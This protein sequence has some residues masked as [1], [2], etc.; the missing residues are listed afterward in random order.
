[1]A[2]LWTVVPLKSM[3]RIRKLSAVLANRIAAGEVVERPASVVK[4]LA[5]NS[6]DAGARRVS[7][8]L[9]DGGTQLIVVVDDGVGM[10]RDDAVLAV[11]RFATSKIT[12]ADDLA[13]IAT[14][15]FRGEALPSIAAVSRMRILT[16]PP[17]A[18]EG[19]E[20]IIEGGELKSV[21]PAGC[22]PGTRVEVA[23]LFFNTPARRKFLAST[24]TERGHCHDWILRL[25]MARPD[26]AFRIS[27]N[28]TILFTSTG[29]GDLLPVL[30]AA[31]GSNAARQFVPV[32][33]Q[34]GNLVIDGYVSGPRL[35]RAT[36]QHQFFFVNRRFVRS[37]ILS[38]ALTQAYGSLL[39]A[40]RQP[41]CALHLVLPATEVDPNVHPTKIEVKFA[42]EGRV[43][44]AVEAAVRQ[45]LQEAGLR[46]RPPAPL[47]DRYAPPPHGLSTAARASR[48]RT[49]PIADKLDTRDDG[50]EVHTRPLQLDRSPTRSRPPAP[51]RPTPAPSPPAG[52]A[53]VLGQMGL[54]YIVVLA[55]DELLIIDQHRAAERVILERLGPQTTP[56]KQF[57]AVPTSLEL[58]PL[59]AAAAEEH[60]ELLAALGFE[61]ERFGPSGWLLRAV[62]AGLEYAAPSEVVSAL[63]EELARWQAPSSA[64]QRAE[65]VRA[66]IACRAAIK[67]GQRL[68]MAEM[69]RLVDDLLATGSPAVC[70]HGDPIILVLSTEE[71]DRRFER[72][73]SGR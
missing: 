38:H 49:S 2:G 18:P 21:K 52:E 46:P 71:I 53:T 8:D 36:R 1:M 65:E 14:M 17:D 33:Y 40:G 58:S 29:A 44:D 50:L 26:I 30:A 59:Q 15:G 45:A 25:A 10:D 20:V 68:S 60:S 61:L 48:L 64:Q 57:L 23:D 51:A 69:Q 7:V 73:A 3:G 27:N 12:S 24:N 66:M 62:P 67:A 43:H 13:H 37:R 54:R 70:P 41:L 19:T 9:R 5:E 56:A 42:T 6:I 63:L 22:P 35:M 28:A 34:S 11:E 32:H 39:P 4:E 16:R 72:P 47:P 31:Y 55:G